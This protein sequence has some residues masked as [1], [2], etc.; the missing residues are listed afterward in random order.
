[1]PRRFAIAAGPNS[2]LSRLICAASMLTGALCTSPQRSPWRCPRLPLQHDLALPRREA[3]QDGQHQLAGRVAGV[4][5]LAAHRQDHQTDAALRQSGFD[6]VASIDNSSAVLRASLSGLVTA[7]T[8]PSRRKARHSASFDRFAVL[9][10]CSPKMLPAPAALRRA[11][12]QRGVRSVHSDC[13]G[14]GTEPQNDDIVEAW[15]EDEIRLP[16]EGRALDRP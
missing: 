3:C 10:T 16:R 2:A 8:S 7:S 12:R 13:V 14:C 4:Q 15:W 6:K 1:M 11:P 9:D 5:P